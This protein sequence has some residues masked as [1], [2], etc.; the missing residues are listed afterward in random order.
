MRTGVQISGTCVKSRQVRGPPVHLQASAWEAVAGMINEVRMI[1]EDI[2]HRLWASTWAPTYLHTYLPT[3]VHSSTQESTCTY[4]Q[5]WTQS[6]SYPPP[7]NSR[8]PWGV[9]SSLCLWI[10]RAVSGVLCILILSPLTGRVMICF[11][12][13][14][15][16]GALGLHS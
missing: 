15:R 10:P 1:R 3:C 11:L 7:H 4:T 8:N 5:A 2:Q 13:L 16:K 14:R 6:L 12:T 9:S